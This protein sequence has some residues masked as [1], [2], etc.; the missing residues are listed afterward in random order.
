MLTGSGT[1]QISKLKAFKRLTTVLSQMV[2][3]R[4][5]PYLSTSHN[6]ICISTCKG[7]KKKKVWELH[8]YQYL[9]ALEFYRPPRDSFSHLLTAPPT[10]GVRTQGQKLKEHEFLGPI[11]DR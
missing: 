9:P 11:T 10:H 4:P 7:K 8:F 1:I 6:Y 5:F 2:S 3:P